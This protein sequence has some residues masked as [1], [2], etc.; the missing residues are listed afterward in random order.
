M[1]GLSK[2]NDRQEDGRMKTVLFLPWRKAS[3]LAF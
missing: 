3:F 1:A 2:T